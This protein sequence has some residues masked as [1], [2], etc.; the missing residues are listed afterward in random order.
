MKLDEMLRVLDSAFKAIVVGDLGNAVLQPEKFN[1]FV[2]SAQNASVILNDARRFDMQSDKRDIDRVG[3]ASRLLK[4]EANLAEVK[5]TFA[6][7]R[8]DVVKVRGLTGLTDDTLEENIARG[9]LE[10]TLVQLM[11]ARSGL[12]MEELFV[13]GDTAS[14]DTFLALTDGWNKLAGVQLTGVANADF[15]ANDVESMLEAMLV[16]LPQQYRRNRANLRFY[17]AFNVENAYRNVLRSRGTGLG[18]QAQTGITP[19]AY[20]GIPLVEVPNMPTNTGTLTARDNIV[21]GVFRDIKME[22]DRLP[23]TETTNFY[24]SAKVDAHYED[25]DGA[26]HAKGAN[27]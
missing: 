1:A 8:L 6:T 2:L 22:M 19:V 9:N 24:V 16:G 13:K 3:Y 5:P 23:A 27:L 10:D 15:T 20:K 18:D 17:V 26:V 7:N 11:G 21:Y 12:D 14:G 4:D 25:E